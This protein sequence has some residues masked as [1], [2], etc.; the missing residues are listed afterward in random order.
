MIASD[1]PNS[2]L[3]SLHLLSS[4]LLEARTEFKVNCGNDR[5]QCQQLTVK[6]GAVQCCAAGVVVTVCV[7]RVLVI[8]MKE[9]FINY[10][11]GPLGI[12]H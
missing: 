10:I 12:P 9:S 5:G 6:L 1:I 4:G 7:L 11:I 2:H 8:F 3:V